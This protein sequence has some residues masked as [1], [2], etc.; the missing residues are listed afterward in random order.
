MSL[1]DRFLKEYANFE[2]ED[3]DQDWKDDFKDSVG[4]GIFGLDNVTEMVDEKISTVDKK[5]EEAEEK[6]EQA[7]EMLEKV[8]VLLKL[9]EVQVIAGFLLISIISY[10]YLNITNA[11]ILQYFALGISFLAVLDLLALL[12][13]LFYYDFLLDL[14]LKLKSYLKYR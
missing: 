14:T 1:V 2:R 7:E 11:G 12:Y 13:R 5:I 4:S 6:L 10:Y 8:M 3:Q 9:I